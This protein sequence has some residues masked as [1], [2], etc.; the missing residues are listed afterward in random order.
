MLL[1]RTWGGGVF[2]TCF[3]ANGDLLSQWRAYGASGGG[4]ALGFS[5]Y[6]FAKQRTVFVRRV[7]YNPKK[8]RELVQNT[9]DRACK[10]LDQVTH[11]KSIGQLDSEILSAF[12]VF[13]SDHLREFLF[14]FKHYAFSEEGEWRVIFPFV[15]D[16]HIDHLKFR[17]GSGMPVPYLELDLGA[18]T[19]ELPILPLVEVVHGP[20]L[21]PQLTKKSLYLMLQQHGYDHVEV[22]GSEAP[23]RP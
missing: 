10:L 14:T 7:I 3:C 6:Q 18:R 13:L 23:L 12:A 15:R 8:Q 20:T 5:A 2:I 22:V 16:D 19:P 4:Y 1:L 9:I 21:H 11:G 17:D